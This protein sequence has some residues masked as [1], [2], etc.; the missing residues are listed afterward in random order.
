MTALLS[1]QDIEVL[2]KNF[3]WQ[4][5]YQDKAEFKLASRMEIN[6]WALLKKTGYVWKLYRR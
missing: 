1:L 3:L 6:T 2:L 4:I 5:S